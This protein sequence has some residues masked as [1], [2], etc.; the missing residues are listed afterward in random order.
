[1]MSTLLQRMKYIISDYVMCNIAWLL[2]LWVRFEMGENSHTIGY[3]SFGHY[4]RNPYVIAGQIAFP[5][6]M[7]AIFWLSGY[8]NEVW[9][10]SRVQEFFDT[11]TSVAT[12]S[13]L[14][15]LGALI[16][17]MV[18][19]KIYNYALLLWLVAIIFVCVYVPR[20]IITGSISSKIKNRKI[21]FP[22]LM[23]GTGEK[24]KEFAD[25]LNG[26]KLSTG[27]RIV[28]YVAIEGEESKVENGKIYTFDELDS[29]C[30]R[31]QVAEL[32]VVPTISDTAVLMA[33][34]NKLYHL[35]LPIKI[36]PDLQ[37]I[38]LSHV[39]ICDF[40]GDPLVDVSGSNMDESSKNIKRVI[41]ILVGGLALVA[42]SPLML[43]IAALIKRDSKGP[44]LYK[45]ERIGLHNKPFKIIKFR[46]MYSD[47]ERASGPRLSSEDDDRITP[48]GHMLRKYRLDEL[49]QFGNVCKGEM[50]LVGP[51]PE[52]QYYIDQIL[53]RA[54]FYA[55]L[56]QV[57]PGLTSMGMVKYGYAKNV[58]EMV[59]RL[60]YDL[61]YMANMSL[62]ND[63]KVIIY[64]IK[65]VVTG[66]GI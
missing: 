5:L 38:L 54:P 17:D 20:L 15:L 32:V 62:M 12:G 59:E 4:M 26:Q 35:N 21:S 33:T 48:V 37:S 50:S 29:V 64:T 42:L 43:V 18:G 9:R 63:V 49:P 14:V 40:L 1:M 60:K 52:R 46:S 57:R 30:S 28:G 39:K 44:V 23:I 58:D 10:K 41:D 8:Y 51:R 24:A 25:K 22:T 66:R 19:E 11:I 31:E 53:E 61:L 16:N 55:I 65:T 6:I 27:Y 13:I 56:H 34:I 3:D 7:L 45:Q 36:S 2:F 47:A